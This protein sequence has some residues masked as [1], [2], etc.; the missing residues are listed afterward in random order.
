MFSRGKEAGQDHRGACGQGGNTENCRK[1]ATPD[2]V[3]QVQPPSQGNRPRRGHRTANQRDDRGFGQAARTG[4]DKKRPFPTRGFWIGQ[5]NPGSQ[6]PE[7]REGAQGRVK[8][9]N[10][11]SKGQCGPC[12]GEWGQGNVPCFPVSGTVFLLGQEGSTRTPFCRGP[13]ARWQIR[14]QILGQGGRTPPAGGP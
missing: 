13:A 14:P 1:T 3:A 7:R 10:Q 2:H 4:A 8:L 11:F 12:D 6:R 9:P 5:I